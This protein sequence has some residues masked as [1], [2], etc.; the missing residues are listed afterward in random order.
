MTSPVSEWLFPTR[1]LWIGERF[2]KKGV[3]VAWFYFTPKGNYLGL[4]YYFGS[5]NGCGLCF[6]TEVS[7]TV[8]INGGRVAG[9][10]AYTDPDG[11]NFDITFDVPLAPSSYGKPLPA[12]G[13]EPARVYRAFHQALASRDAD[14]IRPTL[15]SRRQPFLD[16]PPFIEQLKQSHPDTYELTG[17]YS[18]ENSALL[19]TAGERSVYSS[20]MEVKT[21]VHLI[22]EGGE[23]VVEDELLKILY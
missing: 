6:S 21:E 10:L 22:R 7:T 5:G 12:D 19:L 3:G 4:S 15:D 23:W 14:A 20:S 16:N 1:Q 13:G 17:A 9:T 18:R 8:E 2:A 11:P